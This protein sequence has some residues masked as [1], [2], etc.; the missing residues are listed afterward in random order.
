[1]TNEKP[2]EFN[3][4]IGRERIK[5]LYNAASQPY[6]RNADEFHRSSIGLDPSRSTLSNPVDVL[7]SRRNSPRVLRMARL[8][9]EDKIRILS[10]SPD[11]PSLAEPVVVR[12]LLVVERK[13]RDRVLR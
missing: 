5:C 13:R 4:K 1:M 11:S 3:A 2:A 8:R 12:R 7:D 10:L 9:S 6:P